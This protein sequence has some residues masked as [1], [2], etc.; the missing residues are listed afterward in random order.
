M[1]NRDKLA[2]IIEDGGSKALRDEL[3]ERVA[4]WN[5]DPDLHEEGETFDE[6]DAFIDVDGAGGFDLQCKRIL[7]AAGF[8]TPVSDE[9]LSRTVTSGGAKAYDLK[10]GGLKY[11]C[12]C[13]MVE[14]LD[15]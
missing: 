15:K 11:R 1:S 3:A 2:G 6:V 8:Y 14:W 13:S 7:V 9:Q 10:M 12:A 4:I 5:E